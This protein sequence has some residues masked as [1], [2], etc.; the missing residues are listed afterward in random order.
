MPPSSRQLRRSSLTRVAS[1]A[2]TRHR[3]GSF[4]GDPSLQTP[5]RVPGVGERQ[6]VA[7]VSDAVA[8]ADGWQPGHPDRDHDR[9]VV[10]RQAR[11]QAG[12]AVAQQLAG[13]LRRDAPP[14]PLEPAFDR[15]ALHR[16]RRNGQHQPAPLRRAGAAERVTSAASEGGRGVV[17]SI[18][19]GSEMV[20]LLAT[21][22][23]WRLEGR[24]AQRRPRPR[25][26]SLQGT[27]RHRRGLHR[28]VPDGGGPLLGRISGNARSTTGA[29]PRTQAYSRGLA[30]IGNPMATSVP[31]RTGNPIASGE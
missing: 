24:V 18:S 9:V 29:P 17:G 27:S 25:S 16:S 8:A 6:E 20:L 26:C 22:T 4:L 15:L 28:Q 19:R 21:H 10:A 5:G 13:G 14:L 11:L 12:I 7:E 30:R 3:S 2:M 23:A 31:I 1:P